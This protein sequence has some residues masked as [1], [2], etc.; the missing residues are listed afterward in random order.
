MCLRLL[1]VNSIGVQVNHICSYAPA[2]TRAH[3]MRFSSRL[4]DEKDKHLLVCENKKV[5]AFCYT[6]HVTGGT[7]DD[8]NVAQM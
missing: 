2:C 4:Y 5:F 3:I 1:R 8:V 7:L 6:G